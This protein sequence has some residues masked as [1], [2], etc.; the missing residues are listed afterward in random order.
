MTQKNLKHDMNL[1]LDHLLPDSDAF[2]ARMSAL[3]ASS[4]E[5]LLWDR[6][7]MVDALLRGDSD[8]EAPPDFA[9]KVMA[10]I[11]ANPARARSQGRFGAASSM[12]L[13]TL[14]LIPLAI[15]GWLFIERLLS[16]P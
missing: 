14:I 8:L 9:S 1:A 10:S 7:Q 12:L 16:D 15:G 6:M 3:P 5:A 13:I 11:A 4:R 2:E